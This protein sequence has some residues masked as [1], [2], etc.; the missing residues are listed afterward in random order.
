[1]SLLQRD[2]TE[3]YYHGKGD[4]EVPMAESG[5]VEMVQPETIPGCCFWAASMVSTQPGSGKQSASMKHIMSAPSSEALAD[6]CDFVLLSGYMKAFLVFEADNAII[7]AS[8]CA[9]NFFMLF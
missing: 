7:L 3:I 2:D 9:Q 4:I 8:Y 5:A 1:M 6:A